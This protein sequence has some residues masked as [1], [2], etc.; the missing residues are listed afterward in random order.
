MEN[1][2]K[3]GLCAFV[4]FGIL[5]GALWLLGVR[6]PVTKSIKGIGDLPFPVS[7]GWDVVAAPV[8]VAI[9]TFAYSFR[10]WNQRFHEEID[11]SFSWGAIITV[12]LCL[13]LGVVPAFVI[14]AIGGALLAALV[15]I[16][17]R[18]EDGIGGTGVLLG[19]SLAFAC[20]S[21]LVC[22][23]LPGLV[24]GGIILLA[25]MTTVFGIVVFLF[26]LW[27]IFR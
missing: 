19:C 1:M 17:E 9:I 7:R 13:W 10:S 21:G 12:V 23:F 22:G 5:W 27:V 4:F 11:P 24:I 16:K 2:A 20:S 15:L 18:K 14:T 3:A 26:A 8:L 25:S 6:I